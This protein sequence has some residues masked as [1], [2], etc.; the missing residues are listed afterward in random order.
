MTAQS[1]QHAIEQAARALQAVTSSQIKTLSIGDC[2]LALGALPATSAYTELRRQL[3]RRLSRNIDKQNI[4]TGELHYVFGALNALWH[5][6]PAAVNG[7]HLALAV[8]RLIQA[9]IA[10]G[11]PYGI[12]GN[13]CPIANAHIAL[14]MRHMGEPLPNV[15]TFLKKT[16]LQDNTLTAD[17]D[18]TLYLIH[19]A[20][21]GAELSAQLIACYKT[22]ATPL[23]AVL[24]LEATPHADQ[25]TATAALNYLLN[26]QD[27]QGLWN[28]AASTSSTANTNGLSAITTT[29]IVLKALR[30]RRASRT[31][32]DTTADTQKHT[33]IAR[34]V[35]Q[36]FAA[37]GP[38]V[39]QT[40]K[41][42]VQHI[43]QADAMHETTL[44]PRLF[45]R[46]LATPCISARNTMTHSALPTSACGQP[47]PYT[48]TC[49]MT[50][51]T[52]AS[53]PLP[54]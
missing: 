41:T 35:V 42:T 43:C 22:A 12:P 23:R 10:V 21:A 15:E 38:A 13:I 3:A 18:A 54:T 30:A 33:A 45:G 39:H 8:Q 48:T 2:C 40:A 34:Q 5:Y 7:E 36:L 6:K 4:L 28:S 52:H 51:A 24:A 25:A 17:N 32:A 27:R 19:Q 50:P 29:A 31:I 53:C 14:F 20:V 49:S 46:S 37:S 1:L 26:S 9:E 47:I 44:L 16:A 11:G